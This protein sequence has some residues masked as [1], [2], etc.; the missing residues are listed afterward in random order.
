MFMIIVL[1][2]SAV[3]CLG[4]A[5]NWTAM[6]TT[7][8]TVKSVSAEFE[9]EKHMKILA[10]P[11]VSKGVF[12]FQSPESLRW[13]YKTPIRSILLMHG[14][15]T[16]R[17]I[18]SQDGLVEETGGAVQSMQFVLQEITQWMAGRFDEN[19]TFAAELEPNRKIVLTP[20]HKSVAAL[21]QRIELALSDQPGVIDSVTIFESQDSFTRLTFHN[22]RL[23]QNIP[24]SL[25]KEAL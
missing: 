21:I 15:V 3:L 6:Q 11:L 4:W 12:Y 8:E 22:A 25:F 18:Q 10:R 16:K 7:A 24:E 13:E 1:M 5:D 23:N 14:G 19:A 2:V 17:Y 20:R 9:Q